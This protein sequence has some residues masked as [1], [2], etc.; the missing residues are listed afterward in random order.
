MFSSG[1]LLKNIVKDNQNPYFPHKQMREVRSEGRADVV[2]LQALH[3]RASQQAHALLIYKPD[4][5]SVGA[6]YQTLTQLEAT[7]DTL[8][9]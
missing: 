8:H 7:E 6:I 1:S 4:S 9:M 3:A 2:G 5:A